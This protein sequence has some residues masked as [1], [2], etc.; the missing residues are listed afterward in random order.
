MDTTLLSIIQ[1]AL[2]VSLFVAKLG[3]GLEIAPRDF[4]YFRSHPTLMLRAA[5]AVIV[6]VPIATLIIILV[7]EPPRPVAVALALMAASPAAPFAIGKMKGAGEAHAFGAC[8]QSGAVALSIITTPVVLFLMALALS[9]HAEIRPYQ[10]AQSV[11][12]AQVLPIGLGI[13]VAAKFPRLHQLARPLAKVAMLVMLVILLLLIY[14]MRHAFV[15]FGWQAYLA[16]VL[17]AAAALAF[18]HFLA[19]RDAR[20]KRALAVETALRNPALALMIASVNF[21]QAKP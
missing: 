7:V 9:F 5:V 14:Q 20:M 1:I 10:V 21:P 18:G 4:R 19:P 6:L 12:F 3:L 11:F 8:V 2:P 13:L 15:G 17:S 16:V